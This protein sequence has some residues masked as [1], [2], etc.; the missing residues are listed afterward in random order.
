MDTSPAQTAIGFAL[1]GKWTEAIK[2]NLEIIKENPEDTEALCRLARAYT[3]L[4]KIKEAREETKKVLEIDPV[5]S[6]A[7][8]FQEKLKTAKK[9]IGTPSNQTQ[10]ESFLEEPGRTKLVKLLNLGKSE[11]FANLDP[12]EEV[13]LIS[14]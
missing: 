6:I 9:C 10:A 14:Y 4:G 11:A 8:K 2:V 3:E 5:N 13:K 1:S 12:G 7:L